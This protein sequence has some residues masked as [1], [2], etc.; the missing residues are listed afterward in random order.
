MR[1][2]LPCTQMQDQMGSVSVN[3]PAGQI[4]LFNAKRFPGDFPDKLVRGLRS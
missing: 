4:Q 1:Y 2:E 3:E